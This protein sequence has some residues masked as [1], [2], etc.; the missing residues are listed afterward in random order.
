MKVIV[1]GGAGFIGSAVCRY[2][3]AQPGLSVLNID[4]LTYAGN[5]ASL[6]SIRRARELSFPQGRHLRPADMD[7][8]FAELRARCR[9][10]PRGRE[11]RRPLDHRAGRLHRTNV[12]G[13]FTLLEAA[14]ALLAEP[15]RAG[16]R[17]VPLPPRLDRRG[18]WLARRRRA[19]QR[20]H[21]LRSE[22]ALFGQQGGG[23]PPRRGLASTPTGCRRSS[24]T[25]RTTTGRI[26]FPE[27]LIPLMILNALE[28]K[29]LPV[30]G[31]GQNV[32]DWL[33]VDDHAARS[34]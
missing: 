29:P 23:R 20:D 28:G 9:H 8:A 32:R 15:R 24:P 16:K 4:K 30:Y 34:G 13:T 17:R 6:V 5:P 1:T 2:L 31:D 12:I 3:V 33:F 10:P 27:K 14:R 21:A 22:L 26:S 11:P 19:V 18:L 25:A 7:A